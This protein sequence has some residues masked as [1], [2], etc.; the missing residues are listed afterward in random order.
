MTRAVRGEG[1][2]DRVALAINDLLDPLDILIMQGQDIVERLRRVP[3][4]RI[5][6]LGDSAE[7]IRSALT[8]LATFLTEVDGA[9]ADVEMAAASD[10]E[11]PA[12]IDVILRNAI[13]KAGGRREDVDL[14]L[15][16]L[17]NGLI[18]ISL[19][20]TEAGRLE[21]FDMW[22]VFDA[23]KRELGSLG[24][25]VAGQIVTARGGR[26]LVRSTRSRDSRADLNVRSTG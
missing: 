16:S 17:P 6:E 10:R 7:R 18:W 3:I 19:E 9:I 1:R 12:L 15:T 11:L 25:A 24:L 4:R 26:I 21:T 22:Y 20:G 5:V 23:A 14:Q 2:G 8:K 13:D